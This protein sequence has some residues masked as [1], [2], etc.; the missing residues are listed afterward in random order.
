M[1][2]YTNVLRNRTGKQNVQMRIFGILICIVTYRR[3]F[4]IQQHDFDSMKPIF[5]TPEG[6]KELDKLYTLK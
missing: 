4:D 5:H 1:K 2:L 3:V 6:H